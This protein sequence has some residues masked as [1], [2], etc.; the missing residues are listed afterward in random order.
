MEFAGP[1]YDGT[2]PPAVAKQIAAA[3]RSLEGKRVVV[4][5]R[6]QK[7]KRSNNQNSYYFG[8]VVAAVNQLFREH[9]NMVDAHDTHEF[10]KLRVGKLSQIFVTPDGEVIKSLGSTTKLSTMEFEAYLDRIRA[11]ASEFGL[12]IPLPNEEVTHQHHGDSA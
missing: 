9:G 2:L 11:W 8:V 3:I 1:V 5:I 6:E 4:T 10:L 12:I 7:R